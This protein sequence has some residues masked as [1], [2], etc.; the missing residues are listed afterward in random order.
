MIPVAAAAPAAV[1]TPTID[2]SEQAAF[3]AAEAA[4]DVLVQQQQQVSLQQEFLRDGDAQH[5]G[6]PALASMIDATLPS[7]SFYSPAAADETL[8]S[9]IGRD[10]DAFESIASLAS[11]AVV[12][13]SES[14][15]TPEASISDVPQG[16]FQEEEEG[17]TGNDDVM[18][19]AGILCHFKNDVV[20]CSPQDASEIVDMAVEM[21]VEEKEEDE[22]EEFVVEDEQHFGVLPQEKNDAFAFMAAN[23]V[24]DSL[25]HPDRLAYEDDA[26]EVN[27]L[28]QY[29][30]S[31]LLEIFAVP[32]AGSDDSDDEDDKAEEV[33]VSS[34]KASANASNSNVMNTRRL[35]T[36]RR[37]ITVS[38]SPPPS[39]AAQRHYPG[40]VGF[41]CVHCAD[42]RRK[43]T[44]KS[45]F[46]PL[47][48][49][50]I[51]RE[52]CAWQRI[53]FKKCPHV[54][55][56]VRERYDHYKRIDTSRGKVR[57]W[58]TSARK[59]GLQNN[60]LR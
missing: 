39:A 36:R 42:I 55:D 51:Y 32:Q 26:E 28:H 12:A 24:V 41:R 45:A 22:D 15:A 40:R 46:Y 11:L 19:A 31:D 53:H 52:V 14:P 35:V 58:E 56:G 7:S 37:S 8:E 54:P 29:V 48:L 59:I 34:K 20:D 13:S 21:L 60:P 33:S 1:V 57:Y 50:N 27:K 25:V 47:R 18:E 16:P 43:S 44:S 17:I 23:H 10:A 49:K 30:R 4:D 3:Y 5:P 2:E 38:S 6:L 9:Y